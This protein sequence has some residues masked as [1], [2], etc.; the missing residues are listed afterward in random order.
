MQDIITQN[1]TAPN[2]SYGE[3]LQI[4]EANIYPKLSPNMFWLHQSSA[5]K[6]PPQKHE[7]PLK[8]FA[9]KEM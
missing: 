5:K 3:K 6:I 2:N 7:I 8:I 9:L 1:I 4:K